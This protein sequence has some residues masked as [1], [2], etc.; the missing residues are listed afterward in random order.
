MTG[1]AEE[2]RRRALN[3]MSSIGAALAGIGVGIYLASPL[4]LAAPL[5]L[6]VGLIAHLY[7]M[8]G[9]RRMLGESSVAPAL[10]EQ[11]GYWVCWILIAGVLVYAAL[12]LG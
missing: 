12:S 10:W 2:R 4:A 1:E 5:I 7:G 9:T 6:A 3:M 11:A 8:V